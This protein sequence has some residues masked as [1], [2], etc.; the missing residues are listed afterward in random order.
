MSSA[1]M[2]TTT[3]LPE[4]KGGRDQKRVF[5]PNCEPDRIAVAKIP[6]GNH[7]N[8]CQYFAEIVLAVA[9]SGPGAG[10]KTASR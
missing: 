8:C 9:V 6:W 1:L 3:S 10:T 5:C 4:Q 7:E 2:A